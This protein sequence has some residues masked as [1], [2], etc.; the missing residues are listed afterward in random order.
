MEFNNNNNEDTGKR[1]IYLMAALIG[2]AIVAVVVM[3]LVIRSRITPIKVVENPVTF[4]TS[5]N[6]TGGE[7]T[8]GQTNNGEGAP[9]AAGLIPTKKV[10][11]KIY[12]K[13][14]GGYTLINDATST[15]VRL[16]DRAQGLFVD[17]DPM[18]GAKT[19]LA[20]KAILNMHDAYFLAGNKVL[21]RALDDKGV[22]QTLQYTLAASD[23][24]RPFVIGD[25][26]ALEKNIKEIGVS[27][28]GK[29]AA[30]VIDRDTDAAID[31]YDAATG[32]IN[33]VATPALSEWIPSVTNDGTIYLTAKTAAK[34]MSGVYV[35]SGGKLRPTIT[36]RES[37]TALVGAGGLAFVSFRGASGDFTGMLQSVGYSEADP[38]SVPLA[39]I[40]DKC[41]FPEDLSVSAGT[42]TLPK[43]YCG[44]PVAIP[45]GGFPDIWYQGQYASH[46]ALYSYD[47]NSDA[48]ALIVSPWTELKTNLDMVD[49]RASN[50]VIYFI[51]KQTGS[52]YR[53]LE[54]AGNSSE[55][56]SE[57]E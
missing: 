44:V 47:A 57:G 19:V 24:E 28:N 2:V 33:E 45:S 50:G 16:F 41:A 29:F 27:P 31:L 4:P 53:A 48:R 35:V 40:A 54:P 9:N 46:D 56:G 3:F 6:V 51:D 49:M 12:D 8:A 42:S 38:S 20:N 17:V 15:R 5:G 22:I 39:T 36:S 34:Y 25:P 7:T 1:R 18:T 55:G 13:A 21:V 10:L 11:A 43:I 23:G 30:L 14:V 26:T 37:Q 52:M 32:A